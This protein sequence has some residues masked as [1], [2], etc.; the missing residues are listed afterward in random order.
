MTAKQFQAWEIYSAVEPFGELREDYRAASIR[1]MIFN[2]A[3]A[4]KDRLPVE[5]FLVKFVD[6]PT[7]G[8]KEQSW[9]EKKSI[10]YAI[11]AAYSAGKGNKADKQSSAEEQA[12]AMATAFMESHMPKKEH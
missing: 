10:A 7:A 8:K 1:A 9:Q 3:V 2:M 4:V 11:A 12:A 6:G 5:N